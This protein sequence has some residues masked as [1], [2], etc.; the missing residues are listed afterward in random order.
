[1]TSKLS[2]RRILKG[3]GAAGTGLWLPLLTDRGRS[4]DCPEL[5]F[6]ITVHAGGGWDPTY[7]CDPVVDDERYSVFSSEDLRSVGALNY[8]PM[9]KAS[10]NEGETR[11]YEYGGQD[12]FAKH[13]ARLV[14]INGV[15]TQTVSH[16]VGGRFSNTGTVREGFPTL[17]ALVAGLSGPSLPLSFITTG[18][19]PTAG[20]VVPTGANGRLD[21]VWD[22][23]EAGRFIDEPGYA[24]LQNARYQRDLARVQEGMAPLRKSNVEALALARSAGIDEQ[25]LAFADKLADFAPPTENDFSRAASLVLAAMKE[26]LCAA[27]HLR[28]NGAAFDTHSEHNRLQSY[29]QGHRVGLDELFGGLD[30]LIDRALAE[31]SISSRGLLVHVASEFG[32]TTFNETMGKDHWP[33]TSNLVFSVGAMEERVDSGRVFGGTSVST[34]E[35][36]RGVMARHYELSGALLTEADPDDPAAF[37]VT[38]GHVHTAL[39]DVL[40]LC[41]DDLADGILDRFAIPG[42]SGTPLPIFRQG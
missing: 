31:P 3:L 10:E 26:G 28:A 17:S 22:P 37:S 41:D 20:L 19:P 21:S 38:P 35:S 7:F 36:A 2:R 11:L 18:A 5:P 14:V 6:V 39:R 8:L 4:A 34:N 40:G 13:A 16:D 33:I 42:I 30:Y 1:M 24:I 12:F 32:R 25:F 15:D 27:A 9:A 29:S 23:N